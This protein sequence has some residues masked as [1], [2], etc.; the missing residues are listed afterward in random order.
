M[1]LGN[2]EIVDAPQTGE[3]VEIKTMWYSRKPM[4]YGRVA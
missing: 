4:T 2:D 3:Y 1:Y